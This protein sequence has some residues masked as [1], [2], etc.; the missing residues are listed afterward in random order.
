MYNH[1]P[2]PI[3]SKIPALNLGDTQIASV[4]KD[5]YRDG[6]F[7]RGNEGEINLWRLYNLFTN[8]NKSSYIDN[9]ID[10]SVNAFEFVEKIRWALQDK[11]DN[12]F[13]N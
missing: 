6:S 12:W 10:R 7:C 4:V 11:T 1:L 5:Y 3:Q 2:K 8:A 9:F 13:L